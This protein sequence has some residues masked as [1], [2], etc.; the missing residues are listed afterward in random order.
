MVTTKMKQ[1]ECMLNYTACQCWPI[2]QN[3]GEYSIINPASIVWRKHQVIGHFSFSSVVFLCF[4]LVTIS[5]E[6]LYNSSILCQ[7]YGIIVLQKD[8]LRFAH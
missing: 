6:T 7:D 3:F 4:S 8:H 2:G 1:V 5:R